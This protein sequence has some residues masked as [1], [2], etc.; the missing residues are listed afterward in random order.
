MPLQVCC[1]RRQTSVAGRSVR[2]ARWHQP[3][4]LLPINVP[5]HQQLVGAVLPAEPPRL[6]ARLPGNGCG[7][8]RIRPDHL[9][10]ALFPLVFPSNPQHCILWDYREWTPNDELGRGTINVRDLEPGRPQRLQ[11]A[12]QSRGRLPL[13][14]RLARAARSRQQQQ[15]APE[16]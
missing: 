9:S 15:R 11:L 3:P 7:R 4:F 1:K 14:P 12:I 2:S 16:G 5:E 8:H 10:I 6:L 13:P